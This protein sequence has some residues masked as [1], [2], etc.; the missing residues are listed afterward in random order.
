MNYVENS[1]LDRLE[2]R[3][4]SRRQEEYSDDYFESEEAMMSI[5]VRK[6]RVNVYCPLLVMHELPLCI[7]M[8]ATF[9]ESL[10]SLHTYGILKSLV[11]TLGGPCKPLFWTNITLDI[12]ARAQFF[13]L[14]LWKFFWWPPFS[15][16]ALPYG[17]LI[18]IF[19][20]IFQGIFRSQWIFWAP[21]RDQTKVFSN[22]K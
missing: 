21:I 12:F 15:W 3:L 22:S 2:K 18:C 6:Q 5:K 4:K 9:I 17:T 16:Q 14:D 7:S 8:I 10:W 20:T 11:G 1:N 19:E 13:T